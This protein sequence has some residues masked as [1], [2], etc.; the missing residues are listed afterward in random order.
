[1]LASWL[2]YQPD[3]PALGGDGEQRHFKSGDGGRRCRVDGP[4]E[5]KHQARKTDDT[6]MTP[7]GTTFT[8]PRAGTPSYTLV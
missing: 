4:A 7:I 2:N 6:G 5:M 8:G 1:M 3:V